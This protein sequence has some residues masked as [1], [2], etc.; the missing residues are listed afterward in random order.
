MRGG[1]HGPTLG[2]VEDSTAARVVDE[3]VERLVAAFPDVT[4]ETIIAHV[5]TGLNA[6][7]SARIRDFLPVLVERRVAARLRAEAR[8][9]PGLARSA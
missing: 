5:R 2:I 7:N 6:Y 3:V 9:A 1:A 4:R 8:Q